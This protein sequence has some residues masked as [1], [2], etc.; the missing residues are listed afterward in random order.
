MECGAPDS[1]EGIDGNRS[2]LPSQQNSY[3]PMFVDAQIEQGSLLKTPIASTCAC[4][5]NSDST[6]LVDVALSLWPTSLL[7]DAIDL[8]RN[9]M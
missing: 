6:Y 9:E 2:G 8:H 7:R 3:P 4:T 5:A 1:E